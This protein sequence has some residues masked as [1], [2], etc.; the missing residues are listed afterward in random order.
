MQNIRSVELTVGVGVAILV[1]RGEQHTSL[2]KH[3]MSDSKIFTIGSIIHLSDLLEGF[4]DEFVGAA[5]DSLRKKYTWG[6]ASYTLIHADEV[7][8]EDITNDESEPM[9]ELDSFNHRL[10]SLIANNPGIMVNLED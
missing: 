5:Y 9:N 10:R 6:D 3:T 7:L 8:D 4:S 1:R 2:E